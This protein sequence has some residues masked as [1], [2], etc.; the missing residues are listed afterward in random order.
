[1]L[2]IHAAPQTG[3]IRPPL[4]HMAKWPPDDADPGRGGGGGGGYPGG[5]G[6]GD[7]DF[8]KGKVKPFIAL[9]LLV[10]AGGAAALF[11]G[12]NTQLDKEELT[13]EKVVQLTTQTLMLSKSEQLPQWEK[14]AKDP[15][16][17]VR[18]KQEALK[19]LA[20]AKDPAGIDAAIAALT[21][22]EQ[23]LR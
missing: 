20:W 3:S 5:G 14:W 4:V 18:L 15:E 13:P 23:K 8:K 22:Q 12:V 19:Q 21:S 1:M 16:A 9:G 11:L 10:L 17:N 6:G 7:G 2:E